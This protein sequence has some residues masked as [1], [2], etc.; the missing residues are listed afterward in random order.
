M[1]Q[2]GTDSKDVSPEQISAIANDVEMFCRANNVP[3]KD[4]AKAVGYSPGV[5]TD[6]LKGQYA[7]NAG[8]VAIDLED[9]LV[10]EESRRANKQTTVF[11]WTNVALKIQG[12]AQYCLDMQKVGLI[13]GPETSGLGKTTALKAI[14]QE[15]GPRRSTLITIEKCDANPTGL[16]KKILAGMRLN[17]DGNSAQK[18]AR[19]IDAIKG[20]SHLLMIDQIHN[21]RFAT[22]DRPFYYLMDIYDATQSAQLWCGTSDMVDYLQRQQKKTLDEPLAQIRRRIFPCVNLM[23]GSGGNGG[24]GEG[25]PLVTVEQI[26]DIFSKFKLK[27]TPAGARW[28]C[29]LARVPDSGAL[30][31]C[32]HV[33][34]YGTMLALAAKQTS[35]DVPMLKRALTCG[36]TVKR[37]DAIICAVEQLM[38]TDLRAA[39]SA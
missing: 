10:A 36:L 24:G 6:F 11:T 5:I 2:P 25:E 35:L 3:R 21:L 1:I 37:V 38:E 9:W 12:V 23:D 33:V 39:K 34:E 32:V 15:M 28:L 4:V 16:L 31:V 14:H 8:G 13:Y 18:M 27:L 22:E 7:G 19:I 17:F 29:A 20:R 30:G 26:R